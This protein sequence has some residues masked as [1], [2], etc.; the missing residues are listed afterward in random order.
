MRG[1]QS[2]MEAE[3]LFSNVQ[4]VTPNGQLRG[5]VAVEG[6]RIKALIRLRRLARLAQCTTDAACSCSGRGRHSCA[7]SPPGQ[8][9]K[10]TYASESSAAAVGGVTTVCDMPNNGDRAVTDL[11]RFQKKIQVAATSSRVDFGIYAYMVSHDRQELETLRSEGLMG[12]KYDMSLAG[13]EVSPGRVL[14]MPEDAEDFFAQ[15][16]KWVCASASMRRTARSL[17]SAQRSCVP[18]AEQ[19]PWLISRRAR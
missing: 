14:P 1:L 8:E 15:P 9:Y 4:M 13:V 11:G 12:L 18:L 2:T 7:F 5:G 16:P 19:T 10:A 6:G 17:F 3:Q